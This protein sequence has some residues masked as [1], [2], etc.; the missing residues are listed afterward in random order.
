[1]HPP[2][3]A[4]LPP[5]EKS[6]NREKRTRAGRRSKYR[7][8]LLRSENLLSRT[9][10]QAD[11]FLDYLLSVG[12]LQEIFFHWRPAL[13]D[14]DDDLILELAVAAGCRYIVS[15]NIRDFQGVKR[16]GIEALTPGRF[17]HRIDPTSQPP[18]PPSS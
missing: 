3:L 5:D 8:V 13:H 2:I 14:P 18:L 11:A 12:H 4:D 6:Q 1:V 7:A 15:H 16:W 17:L 9:P 10:A